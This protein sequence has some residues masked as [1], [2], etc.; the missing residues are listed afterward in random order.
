MFEFIRS[1]I[2]S[3][4]YDV[5]TDTDA[6][7]AVDT[8]AAHIVLATFRFRDEDCKKQF[9]EMAASEEGVAKTRQSKGCR[10]IQCLSDLNDPATLVIRQEWD[11][12]A[13]HEAYYQTRVEDGMIDKLKELLEGEIEIARFEAISI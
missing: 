2:M 4:L 10:L 9:E 13:D 11:S 5:T 8:D 12:Q 6:A 3:S 7:D 1:W